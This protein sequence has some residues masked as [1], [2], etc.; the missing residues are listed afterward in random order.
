MK[1][2]TLTIGTAIRVPRSVLGSRSASTWRITSTPTASSPWIAASTHTVGPS[3]RPCTT[4]TGRSTSAPV[5][6]RVIGSD[7]RALRRPGRTRTEP[8]SKDGVAPSAPPVATADGEPGP[9]AD[10]RRGRGRRAKPWRSASRP[11]SIRNP[12]SS[13]RLSVT[14][15]GD[16]AAD[17]REVHRARRGAPRCGPRSCAPRGGRRTGRSHRRPRPR[18]CAC[19]GWTEK[20]TQGSPSRSNSSRSKAWMAEVRAP[21]SSLALIHGTPTSG[22]RTH[23]R[24]PARV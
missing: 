20:R 3:S 19:Q 10:V 13:R 2:R 8:I 5:T 21:V 18:R 4:R 23:S 14:S 7:E 9:A 15:A 1:P 16:R 24:Q 6:S 11:T 12:I 22:R 17:E